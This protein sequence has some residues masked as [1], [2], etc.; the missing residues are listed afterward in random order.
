[1]MSG[2]AIPSHSANSATVAKSQFQP[3][4]GTVHQ[5]VTAT[6]AERSSYDPPA[7]VS[8]NIRHPCIPHR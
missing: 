3:A 2:V 7:I 4:K 5:E 1:M 8:P 6:E